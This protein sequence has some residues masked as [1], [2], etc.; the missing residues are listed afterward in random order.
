MTGSRDANGTQFAKGATGQRSH[1][2]D[3]RT[4]KRGEPPRGQARHVVCR[5]SHP[6]SPTPN[7]ASPTPH[8][9]LTLPRPRLAHAS[10]YPIHASPL[11]CSIG[12]GH[13]ARHRPRKRRRTTRTPALRALSSGGPLCLS[14]PCHR[15][16][17]HRFRVGHRPL[18][19]GAWRHPGRQPPQGLPAAFVLHS[20]GRSCGSP[21]G[22]HG[23]YAGTWALHSTWG[24]LSAA[25][26]L[27]AIER[28]GAVQRMGC[29]AVSGRCIAAGSFL[30]S[31][32]SSW[33][34]CACMTPRSAP[35]WEGHP[36]PAGGH[37]L[38]PREAAVCCCEREREI[39]CSTWAA[40]TTAAGT[41]SD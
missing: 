29:F 36:G 11:P 14:G 19:C 3:G 37:R 8:P 1:T 32:S 17:S 12:G 13:K 41:D 23:R 9:C 15:Q 30:S 6:S 27:G 38:P 2:P 40:A 18:W 35:G 31:S 24:H 26:R 34:L 4:A 39:A 16:D 10:P 22:P 7:P 33:R 28:V 21:L 20:D 5:L 25:Q